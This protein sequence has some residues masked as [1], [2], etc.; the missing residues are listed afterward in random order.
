[1]PHTL[2]GHPQMQS[3]CHHEPSPAHNT[4]AQPSPPPILLLILLIDIQLFRMPAHNV[5][6]SRLTQPHS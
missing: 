4:I 3:D 5:S 2:N 6:N 1:M